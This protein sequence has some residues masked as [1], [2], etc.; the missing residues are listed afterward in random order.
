MQLTD[1]VVGKRENVINK[2]DFKLENDTG[3]GAWPHYRPAK[4]ILVTVPNPF[5]HR[6]LHAVP[7]PLPRRVVPMN[8]NP[9]PQFLLSAFFVM[10]LIF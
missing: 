5:P 2:V 10:S 7:I 3:T 9:L 8:P 4:Y 1:P 6:L